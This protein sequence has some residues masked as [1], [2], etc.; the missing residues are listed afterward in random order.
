VA[1]LIRPCAEPPASLRSPVADI[2]ERLQTIVERMLA[3]DPALRF[4]KP[5][6][7]AQALEL[8]L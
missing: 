2:S 6:K 8:F 7:V 3:N 1:E 4:A 5:E